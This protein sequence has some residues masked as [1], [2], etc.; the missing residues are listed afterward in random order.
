MIQ[1]DVSIDSKVS[2]EIGALIDSLTGSGLTDLNEV[3]GRQ[4]REGAETYHLA[5]SQRGGWKGGRYMQGSLGKSGEFGSKVAA[6]WSFRT[7]DPSGAVIGNNADYYAF[8]V[9]GGTITPKRVSWLTI[10]LIPDAKGRRVADYEIYARKKLFR[11]KGKNVL[12][13]KT[14]DGGVRGVYA[15]VKSVT[16]PPMPDA[17]PPEELLADEF[18]KGWLDALTDKLELL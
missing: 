18:S 2:E 9:N 15:L 6:G 17:I 7:A 16:M 8:K 12:M 11:P 5:F 4:A 3:G 14:D 13:E 10:P 1:I